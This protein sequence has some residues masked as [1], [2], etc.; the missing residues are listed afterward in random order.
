VSDARIGRVALVA[1]TEPFG[2]ID[3]ED[4]MGIAAPGL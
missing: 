2:L 1:V 4:G 3:Q